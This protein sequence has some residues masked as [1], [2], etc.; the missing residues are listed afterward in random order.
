MSDLQFAEPQFVHAL[1]G[2]AVVL[3][4]LVWL[5]ARGG[6]LLGDFVGQAMQPRVVVRTPPWR[7]RTRLLLVA[8]SLIA[9]VIALMRPQW[10]VEF[11]RSRQLGAEI[12]IALDVSRS[13]LAEDVVPNRLERAKAEIRDL[14][15]YLAGDQV[16]LIAF[17]GRA[18]VLCPL[19]PDFGFLRLVLDNVDPGSVARGGTRLEEPIRKAVAG[20]GPAG[21]L[22][23]V[24]LLITDGEDHD[25]FPLDAA[26]EA[27]ERGIRI[28]AIGFGDEAGSEI[29][30]T[31]PATGAR[32]AIT[33][34]D[35]RPVRS[36]LDGEL[37]R[38]L[39]I[40]TEGAYVPAGTGVL[41][42]ESIFEAHIRPLMRAEGAE[43]GRTI[44]QDAFQW[45]LLVAWL[46]LLGAVVAG[47]GRREILA[48][49]ALALLSGQPD[50]ATAQG[51]AASAT[52]DDRAGEPLVPADPIPPT[53][54]VETG[55]LEIPAEPREAF[56]RG[57]TALASGDL[58]EAE[59]LLGAARQRARGD[60][61]TRYRASYDLGW[62]EVAR[63]EALQPDEPAQALE[64]LERAA[65]WFREAI[66]QRPE[67]EAPRRNLEIVLARALAL[68]D[69]L[70]ERD[71]K[72][73][74]QRLEALIEAQ[75][76]LNRGARALVEI[77]QQSDDPNAGDA[78][79]GDFKRLTVDARTLLA[80][81]GEIADLAGDELATLRGVAD[82]ERSPEQAMRIAQLEALLGHHHR[83]RERIGQTR[84]QL[85]RR[86]AERAHRRGAAALE[87]LKRAREQLLD[88]V[89]ILD[90]LLVDASS[91]AAETR[92]L[93][94]LGA[95]LALGSDRE[96]PAL[97]DWLDV[98]YLGEL[99]TSIGE[100]TRELDLRFSAAQ[101][102]VEQA[103]GLEPGERALLEQIAAASPHVHDAAERFD[104]AGAA[105]AAD[106]L[107]RA[108]EAQEAG[109]RALSFARERLLDLR[110]L[111][112][113]AFAD[114]RRI[115][116][117]VDPPAA[118]E[119]D[120]E[121]VPL[122]E[123]APALVALQ[124]R[125]LERADRL[126]TL[127]AEAAA[128]AG[129]EGDPAA[130]DPA[131]VEQ[132]TA[133]RARLES[134]DGLLALTESAMRGALESLGR[135]G[136]DAAA[137]DQTRE[138]VGAAVKGLESLRR[139]FFSI[140]EHLR[141]TARRQIEL[142]DD[143]EA[144]GGRPTDQRAEAFA[145]IATR[146][147]ELATF[148][149]RLAE[150]LHEQALADPA[151]A[152]GGE[153]VDPAVAAQAAER[154]TRAAEL[155]LTAGGEMESAATGLATDDTEPE[156]DALLAKQN[157]AV[158]HLAEAIALL[159]P[160][161]PRRPPEEQEQQ[162]Q[163]QQP[164]QQEQQEQARQEEPSES[165][166]NGAAQQAAQADEPGADPGQILQSVR[167]R[168]AE[169]HR[170]KADGQRGY[171]PVER[172]W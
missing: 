57:V 19:T 160:P 24:I 46:A 106:E 76:Q 13:M 125:N 42:L 111:I 30:I 86:Q 89:R 118:P 158:R 78:L 51:T 6:R 169:R 159:E 130:D 170:R 98:A 25:S 105:I 66:A 38:E 58:D 59:R 22:A 84:S 137:E 126:A 136:D 155:V 45:A 28:L 128:E 21:D 50:V 152:P 93:A 167:D 82:A 73:I 153:V 168:E 154:L 151:P 144:A 166:Q 4:I 61:E 134:A 14:L 162:G 139:L 69:T 149:G 148:T 163:Q 83:A 140:V 40:V 5:E 121:P 34:A 77:L 141:D 97:P 75:R 62:V 15:P 156:V 7:R 145:P 53:G 102:G 1:W 74:E 103:S 101:S 79:R 131:A 27:A 133:E 9:I 56:N 119:D 41:D 124:T 44:R 80:D 165:E 68:A 8:V 96:A 11:V 43:A 161:Q 60:G 138:R 127:L 29:F 122:E 12:M 10:G 47:G 112:E 72:P 91:L 35:G 147:S 132:R 104:E 108:L 109:L 87:H 129:A 100:R 90:G 37:L 150:A 164:E 116:H 67:D 52:R 32:R 54:A 114:Q 142:A 85:R 81:A 117:F 135:V 92:A 99:Q 65:D 31:D 63:A 36:R 16:G 113:L 3:A 2:V 64:A 33:D 110:G 23:R 20:F 18:T 143:T 48:G 172:D 94:L 26:R 95:G 88:P 71:A 171:E 55:R 123:L 70:A 120:A 115:Q 157:D 107:I 146:Q 39:A 17:A 49:I